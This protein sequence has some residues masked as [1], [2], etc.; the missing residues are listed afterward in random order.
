MIALKIVTKI[1]SSGA[2]MLKFNDAK[3]LYETFLEARRGDEITQVY[4]P[5]MRFEKLLLLR[6]YDSSNEKG[7]DMQ[8]NL[9]LV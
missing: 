5:Q 7:H 4:H 8:Q 3:K 9:H 1:A 6:R 2:T